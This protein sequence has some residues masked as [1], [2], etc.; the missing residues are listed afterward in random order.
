MNIELFVWEQ[1]AKRY[2]A[3]G[4]I[5]VEQLPTSMAYSRLIMI[6]LAQVYGSFLQI[7]L[8]QISMR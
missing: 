8:D 4:L 3:L 7:R 2:Y 6:D 1:L 5:Y